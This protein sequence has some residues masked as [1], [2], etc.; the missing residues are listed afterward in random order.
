MSLNE[1]NALEKFFH[2]SG[3]DL[4][5]PGQVQPH[6]EHWELLELEHSHVH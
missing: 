3:Y 6:R 2:L 5:L 4:V 1:M